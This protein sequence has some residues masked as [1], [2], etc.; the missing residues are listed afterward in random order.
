MNAFIELLKLIFG[1]RTPKTES[2]HTPSR[3]D[4]PTI[5]IVPHES[6][7]G[8]SAP[9]WE[10]GLAIV[11]LE[12]RRD[13]NGHL[14]VYQLPSNDGGG[15][16]EIAGINSKYHPEE[17]AKLKAMAPS[18]REEEAAQYIESYTRRMT[19]LSESSN[20]RKGTELFVL[21]TTF[22]RGGGGSAWIVQTALRSLGF[23]VI[24]DRIWGPLTRNALVEADRKFDRQIIDRLRSARES[25]ERNVVGYRANLW[26][27]LVNRWDH[28]RDLSLKWNELESPAKPSLPSPSPGS[29]SEPSRIVLPRE[30]TNTLNEF[31]GTASPT[32]NYLEWF[33][34]PV[35][36]VR[37]Y[38]RKGASLSD[39]TGNGLDD[40]RCHSKVRNQLEAALSAVYQAL[41]KAQFEKEGWHIYGGCFN[42]RKKRG[43]SS[44][45]THSWGIAIDINP[46]ENP[47]HGTD[48]TF[49][50]KAIDIMEEHG[51]LSGGRAWGKDW[52][53]FQAAVPH[54]SSGSYYARHGLPV[55]IQSASLTS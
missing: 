37:L 18:L 4:S 19:G 8:I 28:V 46:E 48:T 40:H 9:E 26:R 38:S 3:G 20:L 12:A 39:R 27:G 10:I 32:G 55:N 6:P 21:D 47:F 50:S 51:F 2:H 23:S 35:A 49:S 22:N 31:Y 15:S 7:S 13:S 45:S 24:R 53:H 17:L 44:L 30:G 29:G 5:P 41:G 43:G 34:F 36:N 25:Y 33:S 54:V 52:M 16:Q 11:D 14:S 42:Y 1:I